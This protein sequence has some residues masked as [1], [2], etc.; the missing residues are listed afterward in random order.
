MDGVQSNEQRAM[1]VIDSASVRKQALLLVALMALVSA[2]AVNFVIRAIA[3][4]LFHV[5]SSLPTLG[6]AVLIIATA[7][8]V[9]GNCF[10][11]FM[12]YRRPHS[13]SLLIF[14]AP[15]LVLMAAGLT[16]SFTSLPAGV[17]MTSA[18]VTL[19]VSLVPAAIVVTMLF[20]LKGLRG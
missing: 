11:F 13:R 16:K 10:G 1:P 9:M 18:L 17:S 2:L 6:I 7:I 19:V 5:P 15:G 12:A 3:F 4:S 14:I 8:P 20:A